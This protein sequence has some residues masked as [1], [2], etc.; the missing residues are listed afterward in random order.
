MIGT[1]RRQEAHKNILQFLFALPWRR[2]INQCGK[3]VSRRP[4]RLHISGK[5]AVLPPRASPR[6]QDPA[7]LAPHMSWNCSSVSLLALP[8]LLS[9]PAMT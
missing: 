4:E 2:G 5:T 7:S 1:I 8:L 9:T 3:G 6:H